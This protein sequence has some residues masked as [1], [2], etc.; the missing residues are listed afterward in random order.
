[1][2]TAKEHAGAC[3]Y[4]CRAAR[5]YQNCAEHTADPYTLVWHAQHAAWMWTQAVIELLR[6]LDALPE[7]V[8]IP[9]VPQPSEE[10]KRRGLLVGAIVRDH[11]GTI[12][13]VV[14]HG[15]GGHPL[16]QI[17]NSYVY[18]VSVYKV[19]LVRPAPAT[20]EPNEEAR[21]RGLY[22]GARVEID[23]AGAD[24]DTLGEIVGW[25]SAGDPV[26]EHERWTA[27]YSAH[28]VALAGGAP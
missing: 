12:A 3:G 8:A 5:N 20:R 7:P 2:T 19:T 17:G 15:S 1:M 9:P 24:V 16:L 6:F 10:A 27:A 4:S 23:D 18:G 25:D 28:D 21:K 26:V 22:I 11:E 14:S 13:R